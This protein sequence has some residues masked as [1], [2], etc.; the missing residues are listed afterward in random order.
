[1]PL[2]SGGFPHESIAGCLAHASVNRDPDES[3]ITNHDCD[4]HMPPTSDR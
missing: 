3:G 1:M 4:R 2:D